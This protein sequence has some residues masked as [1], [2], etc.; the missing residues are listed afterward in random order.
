[1]RFR[2]KDFKVAKPTFDSTFYR[3][4]M[5]AKSAK[6]SSSTR[7]WWDNYFDK[8]DEISIAEY[9]HFKGIICPFCKSNDVTL[10]P[11]DQEFN[12]DGAHLH[13]LKF[14]ESCNEEWYESYV[15]YGFITGENLDKLMAEL[16]QLKLELKEKNQE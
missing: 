13:I 2:G 3:N 12:F 6:V 14:C 4:K 16:K 5:I 15:R 9:E 8:Y 11:T 10:E 7:G 1:M